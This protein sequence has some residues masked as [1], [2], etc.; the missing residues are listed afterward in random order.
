MLALYL[1]GIFQFED[2]LHIPFPLPLGQ[3]RLA[4]IKPFPYHHIGQDGQSRHFTNAFCQQFALIISPFHPPFQ[5]ERYGNDAVYIIKES[6][7]PHFRGNHLAHL[8]CHILTIMIFHVVNYLR[9]VRLRLEMTEC[10]RLLYR[11]LSP[12]QLRYRIVIR[13]CPVFCS[14]QH[15][16]TKQANHVLIPFQSLATYGAIAWKQEVEECGQYCHFLHLG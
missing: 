8:L 5:R 14:G 1:F 9:I 2:I 12:K 16:I 3:M 7:L 10:Y 13:R 4:T 11:Y 6:A 15:S